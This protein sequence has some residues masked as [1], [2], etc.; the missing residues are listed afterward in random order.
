MN[1][2]LSATSVVI[3]VVSMSA[4]VALMRVNRRLSAE[5]TS[6]S[7][8]PRGMV[9]PALVGNEISGKPATIEVR[10]T[11]VPT[12]LFIFSPVCSY[13]AQNWH[14]WSA[15]IASQKQGSWRPVF[16]NVGIPS[17]PL[18]Q[19]A[20]ELDQF[21]TL[22]KVTAGTALAY[23]M[24]VTPETMVLN[25]QGKVVQDWAGVLPSEV[26]SAFPQ[27]LSSVH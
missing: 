15:M 6:K 5:L 4:N 11:S 2:L 8:V 27:T 26:V 20:H 14:N 7:S 9:L 17:T 12:V 10:N 18:F 1:R 24:T 13:C 3:L 21:T 23:R 16:I 22:E 19:R 25:T